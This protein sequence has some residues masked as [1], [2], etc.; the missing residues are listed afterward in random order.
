MATKETNIYRPPILHFYN[1]A[2][3]ADKCCCLVEFIFW[4]EKIENKH[5]KQVNRKK[6]RMIDEWAPESSKIDFRSLRVLKLRKGS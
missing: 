4:K 5:N 3:K 6:N 1:E 2:K